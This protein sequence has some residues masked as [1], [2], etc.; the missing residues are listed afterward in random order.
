[1][2]PRIFFTSRIAV[3][4]IASLLT[5]LFGSL[6]LRAQTAGDFTVVVLPDTQFYSQNYPQIFDSQTQWIANNAAAQNIQLVIGVGD[7]V[8]VGTSATQWAN[9]THSASI[10]DQAHVPYAFAIGN[11]DYDTLPPTSRTATTFNQYFGPSRYANAAYYGATNYPPG[12]NE[13]FYETFTW[14]GRSYLILVLEFVPRNSALAWAKSVLDANT[15]KEVIVATH[16]YLYSDNTTVDECDT[17]DMVGDNNGA[18]QWSKLVSQFTNISVVLSGHITNQFNARR[19][20]VGAGGNFVHQIF[21]NW[22]TWT[23]GGNGYFRVMQFSPSNN[24]INVQTYS[25][26]TGLY[27]TDSGDQFTLKWHTDG[28]PGNGTA[29]VTGRVRSASYGAGCSVISGATISVGGITATTDGTGRY[30]LLIPPSQVSASATAAGYLASSQNVSLNDYFPNE[31]D[32]FLTPVPPCPQSATDPSVTICT[33]SN[34]SAVS[35]P[36]N[37]VAGTNSSNPVISLSAWLDGTNVYSTSSAVLNT[38]LT[39]SNG[40]HN[41]KV[42]GTNGA[43]Q[44]FSQTIGITTPTSS[45]PGSCQASPTVPSV[46]ICVPANNSSLS[47]PFTVQAAANMANLVSNSQIWLDGA[48]VYQVNSASVNTSLSTVAGTHRLTVQSLDTS[49][50]LTK[51]T[52][53]VTVSSNSPPPCTL[54]PVDPSVT[55]CAPAPNSSVT[56][57]VN[58]SAG[59]T[60]SAATVTNMYV[61]VDGVKHWTSSGETLNTSLPMSTGTH[62]VTVQAKDSTGHYFQSTEYVTVQ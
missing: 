43:N 33:P 52:I 38:N 56:S 1:M 13:N 49:N 9:A 57:P 41:L 2:W 45:P 37:V 21:A 34:N 19:S 20:D 39:I 62:R 6:P 27:L 46:N 14:G 42:Q 44:T 54:S 7:I 60:E 26:Y 53:Y 8:N 36:V 30:S 17:A 51:Q 25:P 18:M 28:T 5:T 23:N 16:S 32:F 24:T 15:D 4:S 10:L 31:L 22:Q 50:A 48:K 58:I 11:H 12:S 61:W 29:T 40:T 47:S 35:S 3:F 59:S 55:I